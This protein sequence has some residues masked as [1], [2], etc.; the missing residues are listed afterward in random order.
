MKLTSS[1]VA[2]ML[3]LSLLKPTLTVYDFEAGIAT[4]RRLRTASVCIMPWYLARTTEALQGSG[5]HPCTVIGFPHGGHTTAAKVREAE[6]ALADGADELDIV[7]NITAALSGKWDYVGGEIRALTEL[8][9]AAG[10]K[11]K[12]IFENCFLSDE[13]KIR[14]CECCAEAAVDWVKTSTGFGSGGAVNEDLVLMRRHTPPSIQ[15]KAAGGV[16][17]FERLKE[18]LD[19]GIGITRF[20]CTASEKVVAEAKAAL[21]E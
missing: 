21:G 14:V 4:A 7:I 12:V 5:V 16:R 17:S 2:A 8:T 13:Q 11:I 6:I 1:A 9:H 20:G 10:K 3:D 19:L 18:L 15:L